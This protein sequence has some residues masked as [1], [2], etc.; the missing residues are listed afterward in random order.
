MAS[1][2]EQFVNSVRQL[3]AQGEALGRQA[4]PGRALR[5]AG[6]GMQPQPPARTAGTSLLVPS[7]VSGAGLGI[8]ALRP[9]RGRARLSSSSPLAFSVSVA[10]VCARALG[11]LATFH[12]WGRLDPSPPPARAPSTRALR[13]TVLGAVTSAGRLPERPLVPSAS[14]PA[15]IG[16]QPRLSR[17]RLA[18]SGLGRGQRARD[19]SFLGALARRLALAGLSDAG[20]RA[21]GKPP[22]LF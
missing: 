18:A 6:T 10:L 16:A 7:L 12:R 21:L 17:W 9:R 8:A 14:P 3:S 20:R 1:A 5:A 2:L 15:V 22:G 11:D 19:E 13:L 4:G